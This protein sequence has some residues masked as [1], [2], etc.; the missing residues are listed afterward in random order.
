MSLNKSPLIAVIL[1]TFDHEQLLG[2]A[3]VM[4]P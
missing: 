3:L 1:P 2:Q 4:L